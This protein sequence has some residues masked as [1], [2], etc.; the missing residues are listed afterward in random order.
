MFTGVY[1]PV[2]GLQFY[3][4]HDNNF[5]IVFLFLS[6]LSVRVP[7]LTIRCLNAVSV[8][9]KASQPGSN[10]ARPVLYYQAFYI[11]FLTLIILFVFLYGCVK[12]V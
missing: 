12:I 1:C 10:V 3:G 5:S 9:C 11:S 7:E 4:F 2:M 6:F 8:R